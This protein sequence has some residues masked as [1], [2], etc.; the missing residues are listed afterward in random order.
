MLP[1]RF[2]NLL[3]NGAAGIAV[4]MA[5]NIPP[6]HLA[7]VVD[8]IVALIDDPE[9]D[10]EALMK[11]V[12][13]P[14]FPTGAI[15]V[16][17]SG[18]RDA[19][20][21]GRGRI[22]MRARA[23]IEELRGG[24]T[25]DRDHRAALRRE[26]GRRRRRDQEDRRPRPRQGAERD[27]RPRR[28]LRQERDADP[29]RAEARRRAAGGAEQALQAHGAP[30]DLR[31]QRGRARRRR[32]AHAVAARARPPLPRLPA[33]GRHPPL[34]VRAAQGGGARPHPP[35]LPDRARQP[36]R[37][38][39]ADPRRRRHRRGA[40]RADGALRADR[41]PGA[42][43]PRPPARAADRARAQGDRGRARR[44]RGEDR[45]AARDPRRRG[46]H[47]RADPRGAAR[48]QD[49]STAATTTA[50]PRSSPPR[51]SSSSRT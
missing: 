26:E 32:A 1:A 17:R 29:G 12:K 27:L 38:D 18:I 16:G 5:T 39:R 41:D 2:P 37:G 10:V 45:R 42:G 40:R 23:H 20:R 43:D 8:A 15:I 6:H 19:Y 35:R 13:G 47:R 44:A 30:V 7:E 51:R 24:R 11:L 25:R 31:L 3:V 50:A 22:V 14:D 36:R 4:G 9:T 33:R 46:P 49:R 28:P 21:T 34:A 48:A